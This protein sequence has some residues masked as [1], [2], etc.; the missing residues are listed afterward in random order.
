MKIK[1]ILGFVIILTALLSLTSAAKVGEAC[2]GIAGLDPGSNL[3]FKTYLTDHGKFYAYCDGVCK[4]ADGLNGNW[5]F[6]TW[7]ATYGKILG[8]WP[9]GVTCEDMGPISG[10]PSNEDFG[11]A[12]NY[13]HNLLSVKDEDS[14]DIRKYLYD[15]FGGN[16]Y[17]SWTKESGLISSAIDPAGKVMYGV[18]ANKNKAVNFYDSLERLTRTRFYDSQGIEDYWIDYCYDT[19]C[20]NNNPCYAQGSS[21]YNLLCEIKHKNGKTSFLYDLKARITQKTITI[22][23]EYQG[24]RSYTFSY[25]YNNDDSLDTVTFPEGD[26]I[27]YEYNLLGQLNSIE[28]NNEKITNLEYNEFGGITQKEIDPEGDNKVFGSFAYDN[29]NQLASIYYS[30]NSPY[31]T[32]TQN[33]LFSRGMRYD[34]VGNID[35]ISYI[36]EANNP[37]TFIQSYGQPDEDFTYDNLYRL[38]NADYLTSGTNFEFYYKNLLGDRESKLINGQTTDYNYE[39]KKLTSTTS[40]ENSEFDYDENGNIIFY[41]DQSRGKESN[42]I[43]DSLNRMIKSNTNNIE[44]FYTYDNANQRVV[45]RSDQ[46]TTFYVYDAGKVAMEEEIPFGGCS[47]TC[48]DLNGD[49]IVNEDDLNLLINY[50]WGSGIEVTLCAANVDGGLDNLVDYNDVVYLEEYVNHR[51]AALSCFPGETKLSSDPTLGKT[52]LDLRTDLEDKY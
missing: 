48:G 50:I 4:V 10:N 36:I 35:A 33:L 12:Y 3:C 1:N 40:S 52:I 24:S 44:S 7:C 41:N 34:K 16:P 6:P 15:P 37:T 5:D 13:R 23:D 49:N 43:Y 46:G 25:S 45:K 18:D 32:N 51:G 14:Q 31:S 47:R 21:S 30:K 19:F 29:K 20:N 2:S 17:A 26:A 42:Y 9:G 22:Y 27:K 38:T 8:D 28:Y 39:N 11:A